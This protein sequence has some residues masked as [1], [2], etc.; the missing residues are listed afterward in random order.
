MIQ[1]VWFRSFNAIQQFGRKAIHSTDD[2]PVQFKLS[3]KENLHIDNRYGLSDR[4]AADQLSL[5]V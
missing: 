3:G 2:C 1:F 5:Y 4:N